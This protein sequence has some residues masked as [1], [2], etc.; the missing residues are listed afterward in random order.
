[1][2]EDQVKIGFWMNETGRNPTQDFMDGLERKA[3]SKVLQMLSMIRIYG[4]IDMR[5]HTRKLIG[6]DL[7]EIRILGTD[8]IR[9]FY[10]MIDMQH[11]IILHGF[12]KKKQKTPI[13]EIEM[14][15]NRAVSMKKVLDK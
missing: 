8:N 13:K 5:S 4:L 3:R 12:I 11:I 2:G 15:L 6:V 14:A 9:L 10:K 1:M 7:W